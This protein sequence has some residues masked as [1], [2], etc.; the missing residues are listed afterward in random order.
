MFQNLSILFLSFFLCIGKLASAQA[1]TVSIENIQTS[2]KGD[3][4]V[5]IYNNSEHFTTI[6]KEVIG[7]SIAV[8]NNEKEVLTFT[9]IPPGTYSIAVFHDANQNGKL[10]KNWLGIPKEGYGFSKNIFGSLGP[11]TFKETN[12]DWHPSQTLQLSIGL[13]Y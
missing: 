8:A 9:Y 11:P 2:Q 1:L 12:F 10:D 13:K 5:G 3:I 7:K 6:G 4:I